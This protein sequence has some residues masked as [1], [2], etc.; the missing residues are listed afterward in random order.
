MNHR[1]QAARLTIALLVLMWS[2]SLGA[3]TYPR[4]PG[5]D[6]MHYVFRLAMGDQSDA[7]TGEATITVKFRQD[8]L[9]DL[10]L[11][12]TSAAGGKGM[13][14]GIGDIGW[15][16]SALLPCHRP[17]ARHAPSALARGR[18]VVDHGGCTQAFPPAGCVSSRIS[19]ASGPCSARTGR[20]SRASGCR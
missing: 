13:T 7:I 6:A 15:R 14:V 8:G 18:R 19:T 10:W 9:G 3:D 12:L 16:N 11:D 5:V 17:V 20:T 4:Q 1:T 2:V